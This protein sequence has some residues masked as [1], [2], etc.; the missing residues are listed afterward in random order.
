MT[1]QWTGGSLDIARTGAFATLV[2]TQ[3]VHSF[4]CRGS[5]DIRGNLFLV[6]AVA[7]SFMMILAVIY[8]EYLQVIFHTVALGIWHWG[9]ICGFT[10]LVPILGGMLDGFVKGRKWW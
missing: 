3:L 5:Y 1:I 4:E 8:V 6:A 7:L 9:I 2:L 10:A